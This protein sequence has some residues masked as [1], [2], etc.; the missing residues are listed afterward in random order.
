MQV[1]GFCSPER[2][3]ILQ[4]VYDVVWAELKQRQNGSESDA[5]AIR[6]RLAAM[7]IDL[8][9]VPELHLEL[10]KEELLQRFEKIRP[11]LY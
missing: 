7:V 4:Q 9:D 10:A 1:N 6:S 8:K 2:F 11:G 5:E 3:N